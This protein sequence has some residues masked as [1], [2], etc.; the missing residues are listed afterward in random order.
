[1]VALSVRGEASRLVEP[2][3]AVLSTQLSATRVG[4]AQA[5]QDVA[6]AAEALVADL[7]RAGGQ[8]LSVDTARAPLTWSRLS[9]STQPVWDAEGRQTD[10]TTA[11]VEVR[12]VVR[13]L[14][15][16]DAVSAR[17][18]RHQALQLHGVRWR[19]DDDNP[20]WPAV[21]AEAIAA[22]LQKGRDY[23]AAL[24][25]ELLQVEHV[26]DVGLLGTGE[27]PTAFR[28]LAMSAFYA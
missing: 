1:M 28:M 20:A 22:A 17:L 6:A 25:G 2:D 11:T 15:E 12:V 3:D 18:A 24:G 10:R 5:L 13:A 7:A 26:A 21:R 8:A 4:A 16:L 9:A 23:A 19:V 27:S 14:G